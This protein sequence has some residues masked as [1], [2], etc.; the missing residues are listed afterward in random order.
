MTKD[1]TELY[2]LRTEQ[3]AIDREIMK[4]ISKRVV[5]REKISAFRI[6]SDL[7]TVD[8]ARMEAVLKQAEAY[9]TE[10][11][12]PKEMARQIFDLLI[13]WSHHMDR[14]WRKTK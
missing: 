10:Y 4:A 13:G 1:L 6:K 7:P 2:A 5:I 3:D 9:A 8:P 14:E 12:V 11:G